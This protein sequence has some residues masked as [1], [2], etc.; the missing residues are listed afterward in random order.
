[1]EDG[2]VFQ[3]D[4]PGEGG[5]RR[6]AALAVAP[7]LDETQIL[8]ALRRALDPV[9]LPASPA[10]RAHVAAQR[11][12]KVAARN[13]R[14]LARGRV[15]RPS[16]LRK[17]LKTSGFSTFLSSDSTFTPARRDCRRTPFP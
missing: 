10:L 4:E 2:I 17:P 8:S 15:T 3:L 1:V 12:R 11:N 13:A 16:R 9:F 6:I 5:V 7:M 14:G